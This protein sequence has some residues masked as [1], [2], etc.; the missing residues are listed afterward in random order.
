MLDGLVRRHV[1]KRGGDADPAA[2]PTCIGDR[3]DVAGHRGPSSAL[4]RPSGDAAPASATRR[5]V[6][7]AV[8]VDT[9][10]ARRSAR[11]ELQPGP[12]DLGRRSLPPAAA[13]RPRRHRRRLRGAGFRAAP[14]GRAQADPAPARRRPH[15]PRPV[16]D[17]GRGHRP[18]GTS[19]ASCRSMAWG[20][21]TRAG[22]ST[23]CGSSAARAS[24]RPSRASTRPIA[25]PG[26]DPAE[27]TLALRQ[28]LRR[29][30]DVCHAIAYAHSRGVI[31]RDLKPANIL[32][33]PYGETLVVDWGLAKV[34]GRDDPTPQPAAEM[35]LR[36]ASPFGQ[37]RDAWRAPRSARRRT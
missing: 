35:T 10:A 23:P 20:R 3:Q 7:A 25:Q 1:E 4:P 24:R 29:F 37:Q 11:L 33:G 17:R 26:R 36:P 30:I 19:R 5:P 2:A 9:R 18:A 32:L 31:H 12:D 14:R 21:A 27:R 8:D 13:P 34:V 6:A 22:R 28:L 16:P 15:Q